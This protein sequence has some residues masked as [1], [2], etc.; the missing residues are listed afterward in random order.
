MKTQE[1]EPLLKRVLNHGGY[2]V[3]ANELVNISGDIAYLAALI[4]SELQAQ[5]E[6][7]EKAYGGCHKCYGK[8][9]ASYLGKFRG[10]RMEW[11]DLSMKFCDCGRGKQLS[12]YVNQ[13]I[14]SEKAE[15]VKEAY[16][17]Q[18]NL[19]ELCAER[20]ERNPNHTPAEHL[21]LQIGAQVNK[22][23][24]WMRQETMKLSKG[25]KD[26]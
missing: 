16:E 17:R 12:E 14:Q 8:G 9:Y 19:G 7:L 2:G 6:E 23:L 18:Y 13:L 11:P 5:R 1:E 15:A 20:N 25:V 10:G 21:W 22:D 26:E 4:Q 24:Y 3:V